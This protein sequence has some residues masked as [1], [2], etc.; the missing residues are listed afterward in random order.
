MDTAG[1]LRLEVGAGLGEGA[2]TILLVLGDYWQADRDERTE[3]GELVCR[4]KD[5][6]D[7]RAA[8]ELAERFASLATAPAGSGR[9]SAA[10]GG[11]CP[12]PADAGRR[13]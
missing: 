13:R 9:R 2:G 12:V 7:P 3:I 4:A 10:P 6:G 1:A 5:Q 8:S 11:A